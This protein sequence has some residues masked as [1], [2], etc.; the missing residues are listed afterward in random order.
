[1]PLLGVSTGLGCVE[2]WRGKSTK[3]SPPMAA[4]CGHDMEP[5]QRI[6]EHETEQLVMHRNRSATGAELVGCWCRHIFLR[7]VRMFEIQYLSFGRRERKSIGSPEFWA[8]WGFNTNP[9][10]IEFQCPTAEERRA[11]RLF[12]QCS[13]HEHRRL[14]L[15]SIPSYSCRRKSRRT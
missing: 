7:K 4:G 1:M 15:Q 5:L 3:R 11:N 8:Y 10:E 14:L 12:Q 2:G 13:R 9:H 6:L